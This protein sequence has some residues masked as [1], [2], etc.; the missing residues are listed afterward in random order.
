MAQ[1]FLSLIIVLAA[2]ALGLVLNVWDI[3]ILIFVII[4]II[5]LGA[6]RNALKRWLI[7]LM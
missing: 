6:M 3:S 7:N 5:L 4:C 2:M 1:I